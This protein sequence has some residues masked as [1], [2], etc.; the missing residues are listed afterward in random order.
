MPQFNFTIPELLRT[1]GIRGYLPQASTAIN[2]ALRASSEIEYQQA[3]REATKQ[4]S[5]FDGIQVYEQDE[6]SY[7]DKPY[8][9]GLPV[10]MPLLLQKTGNINED[11][12]L[13]AAIVQISLPRNIVTTAIQGRNGTVKEYISNGDYQLNVSGVLARRGMGYPKDLVAQMRGF[14]ETDTTI[15]VTSELLNL[16]GVYEIV[17]TDWNLPVNPHINCAAYTFTAISDQPIELKIE[18]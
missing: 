8:F 5:G 12:L 3:I 16:L 4:I 2:R 1:I 6:L 13:D 9:E 14:M 15:P 11:M 10:W 7:S 18:S 17:V